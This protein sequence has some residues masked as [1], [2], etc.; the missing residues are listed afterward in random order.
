MPI[1]FFL[2]ISALSCIIYKNRFPT[3]SPNF[4]GG[5]LMRELSLAFKGLRYHFKKCICGGFYAVV[6]GLLKPFMKWNRK[7]HITE[8][9]I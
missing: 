3:I 2:T 4:E 6:E 5:M 1:H 9:S 7:K 8:A